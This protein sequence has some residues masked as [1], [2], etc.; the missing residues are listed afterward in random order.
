MSVRASTNDPAHE[1][2]QMKLQSR[3]L[4]HLKLSGDYMYHLI[5]QS[6]TLHYVFMGLVWFSL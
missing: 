6:V 2:I 1:L 4:N 3:L 5:Y